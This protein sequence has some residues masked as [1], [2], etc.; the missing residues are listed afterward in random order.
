MV[1]RSRMGGWTATKI[2]LI[3]GGVL[4]VFI[5]IG[6]LWGGFGM[7]DT[8]NWQVIQSVG[9]DVQVRSDAGW[10]FR[11]FA[12]VTTYPRAIQEEFTA[13]T[14]GTIDESINVTF[15]DSGTA[16]IGTLIRFSTPAKIDMRLR[17]HREFGGDIE[18]VANSVRAHLAN[19]AKATAP[20][21]SSSEHQTARKSE[22]RQLI[23]EQLRNGLYVTRR[24]QKT[25]SETDEEGRRLHVL[26]TEIIM[27]EN[28]Q[29]LI[30]QPSPLK[31]YGLEILQFSIK[32]TVYDSKT[33]EKFEAKKDSFLRAEQA[34]VDREQEVQQRLMIIDKGKR[35]LAEIE[36]EA[37]KLKMSATVDAD[38]KKEIA[39][40]AAEM[41][42]AVAE[43]EKIEAATKASQLVEVAGMELEQ[44]TL[45]AKTAEK[46]AEAIRTLAAAEE[47][48]IK[49]GGA[50]TE[51]E[52]V[53]AQIMADR[54]AQVAEYLSKIGVPST[55]IIGGG[56]EGSGDSLG[57]SLINLLLLKSAGIIDPQTQAKPVIPATIHPNK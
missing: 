1:A 5:V 22:F 18:N 24:V 14:D 21:M 32:E 39:T 54:D 42:V 46:R 51:K 38:M 15:N 30:A 55:V 45:E 6:L 10:Y 43:Q 50:I 25:L 4:A 35:E 40:T 2:G 48:K 34:K 53:L 26:A 13:H 16:N 37:N 47:E 27:D 41:R 7:N 11:K 3:G 33:L 17:M 31:E 12:T 20:M 56:K 8:Q 23:E 52:R 49:K 36:A 44:A 28:G 9:G 57:G 19:C 29:P